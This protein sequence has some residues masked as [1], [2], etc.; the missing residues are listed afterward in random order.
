[1]NARYD[2][3][4]TYVFVQNFNDKKVKFNTK[5]TYIDVLDNS[6]VTGDFELEAFD[7]KVFKKEI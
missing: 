2:E 4:N 7:A 5:D 6:I 3:K 1:V